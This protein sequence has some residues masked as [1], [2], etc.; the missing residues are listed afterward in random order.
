[1]NDVLLV[2]SGVLRLWVTPVATGVAG[3]STVQ[4]LGRTE[5][6]RLGRRPVALR[7]TTPDGSPLEVAVA[8]EEAGQLV[9]PFLTAAMSGLPHAPRG[10]G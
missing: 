2:R 8:E 4:P 5:V 7:L 9:G 3:D 1:V 6:R 10:R